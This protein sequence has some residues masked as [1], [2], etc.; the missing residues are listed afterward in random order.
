VQRSPAD[1]KGGRQLAAD[2]HQD[3]DVLEAVLDHMIPNHLKAFIANG[4]RAA[5]PETAPQGAESPF[6]KDPS[7]LWHRRAIFVFC[8]VVT[9]WLLAL[10]LLEMRH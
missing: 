9:A 7:K 1:L 10:N 3:A 4:C 5:S 8:F 6:K 2:T